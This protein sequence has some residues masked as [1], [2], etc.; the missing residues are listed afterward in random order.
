MGTFWVVTILY[1]TLILKVLL[2]QIEALQQMPKGW[3]LS[4]PPIG[5]VWNFSYEK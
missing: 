2:F 5:K 3:K 4:A 1:T